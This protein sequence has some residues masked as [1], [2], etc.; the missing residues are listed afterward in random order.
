MVYVFL[1]DGFEEVEAITP[2]DYLRRAEIDVKTVSIK[3]DNV[4]VGA[5]NIKVSA[6]CNINDIDIEKADMIVL[7]GGMPGT[8]NL[9]KNEMLIKYIDYCYLNN[10]FIG[11]ICASPMILGGKQMLN[12][13]KA[14]CYPSFEKYLLG[15]VYNNE[16]L[17][18]DGK[19]ITCKSAGYAQEFAF[20][21]INAL[22]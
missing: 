2:I 5:H 6:D 1:A 14:T 3:Q 15:A 7:P 16:S 4:V 19:I 8:L 13:K 9:Q 18:I 11:A 12:G 22:K 21:L 10:I 20:A 17:C